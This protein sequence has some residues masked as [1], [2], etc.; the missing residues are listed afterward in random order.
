M[1]HWHTNVHLPLH[2]YVSSAQAAI[3]SPHVQ[4]LALSESVA[5]VT[6]NSHPEPRRRAPGSPFGA[7]M[8]RRLSLGVS[9]GVFRGC[10]R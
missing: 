5:E 2:L 10:S 1:K 9:H 6:E 3:P 4:G 7:V 8:A